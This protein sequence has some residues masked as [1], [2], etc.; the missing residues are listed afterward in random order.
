MLGSALGEALGHPLDNTRGIVLREP[1][2][3]LL[4]DELGTPFPDVN[5]PD[6]EKRGGFVIVSDAHTV[7][8]GIINQKL[9]SAGNKQTRSYSKGHTHKEVTS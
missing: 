9:S 8:D 5:H 1:L 3:P 6:C 4:G 7:R 2:G